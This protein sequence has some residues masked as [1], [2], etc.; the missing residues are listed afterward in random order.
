MG[1]IYVLENFIN[2]YSFLYSYSEHEL[3]VLE[4]LYNERPS[5][6]YRTRG[7]GASG[8]PEWICVDLGTYSGVQHD[9]TFVGLFNHNLSTPLNIAGGD[10]LTLR[11]CDEGCP[12]V[13]GACDWEQ[14]GICYTDLTTM[15]TDAC[16]DA[17]TGTQPIADFRNLYHKVDCA[18]G[19]QYWLLEMIDQNNTDGYIEIGELV[20]GRW[21]EF[22]RGSVSGHDN[23]V[24]L[25]PGRADG[26]E[27]Y[28]GKQRTHYGQDWVTYY[29]DSER[30]ELTFTNMNDACVVDEVHAFLRTVQLSGGKFIIVPDDTKPFCYYVVIEN[31]RDYADRLIYGGGKELREWRLELKTLT[32][33]IRLL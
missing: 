11:G 21:S 6:P 2:N 25:S 28:M 33:G 20:L 30:F 17:C 18:P 8:T 26:P 27:F 14:T 9:V 7:V 16:G 32:Q 23:W 19:H 22:H 13:S 1:L 24:R 10:L 12:G 4:N 5:W 31:L 15:P 29:S 3:Y